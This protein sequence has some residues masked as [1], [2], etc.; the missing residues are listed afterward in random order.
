MEELLRYIAT[1]LVGDADHVKVNMRETQTEIVLELR[2]PQADMGKV[3]GR[4]GRI[5][6]AIRTLIKSAAP[7][8]GRRVSVDI[9]AE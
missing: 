4:Q 1:Q 9:D 8:D 5:A 2:V 7:R 6:R 3:I